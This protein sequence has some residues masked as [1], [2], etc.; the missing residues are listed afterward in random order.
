MSI[1]QYRYSS[2]LKS[3]IESQVSELLK[4]GMIQPSRSPFSSLVLLV[5]KRDNSWCMCIDYRMLNALTIKSKFLILVIDELLDELADA[6]W[7]SCLDLHAGFNP[8]WLAPGEEY[9]TAFQTHWG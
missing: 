6:C 2:K 9:K 3:E 5:R 7:F 4:T 1:R 8:I